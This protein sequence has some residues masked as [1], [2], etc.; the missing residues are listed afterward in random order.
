MRYYPIFVNL[1]GK[2]CLVV[3]A[4]QV[5]RR[6]IT[7]LAESGAAAIL[8]VDPG[9]PPELAEQLSG[10][11]AVT[12]AA[13]PF[14]PDDLD[15]RFLVIAAT[16]DEE[17][18]WTISRN[19]QGGAF[20][21]TSWTSRKNAPLSCRPFSP[22]ANSPW[23]SPPA[24]ARRPWPARS[25]KD[26]ANSW[27]A[28]TGRCSCSWAACGRWSSISAWAARPMPPFSAVW[29][30]RNSSD[31]LGRG[32]AQAAEAIL[33]DILPAALADQASALVSGALD[34]AGD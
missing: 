22:R 13:R 34:H 12:L 6:K 19:A 32:D 17:Q 31:A 1:Q 3:G 28:N 30:I 4:G 9:L 29:S 5:G 7:G 27:A 20:S 18:N 25:G 26:W 2:R 16:D 24:A 21:A 23:P 8:V 33:R 11:P 14:A 10:L 15:D